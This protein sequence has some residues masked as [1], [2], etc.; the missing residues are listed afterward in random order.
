MRPED[1]EP[2]MTPFRCDALSVRMDPLIS[3]KG[4]LA[5]LD[6]TLGSALGAKLTLKSGCFTRLPTDSN[7]TAEIAETLGPELDR[8][9]CGVVVPAKFGEPSTGLEHMVR[10]SSNRIVALQPELP[11][12]A[13]ALLSAS[14]VELQFFGSP[15]R[16][17]QANRLA[18]WIPRMPTE[19]SSRGEMRKK[20]DA[21]RML[22]ANECVIGASIVPGSIQDDV[23]LL[24]DCGIDYIHLM[25]DAQYAFTASEGNR[26]LGNPDIM[27][28]QALAVIQDA[29]SSTKLLLSANA[30][31]AEQLYAFIDQGAFA[32]SIDA[33]V[34]C[35]IPPA[36]AP[37]T[38]RYASV[39]SYR[40]KSATTNQWIA[41]SINKMFEELDDLLAY[42]TAR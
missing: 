28:H 22:T 1:C 21:I 20:I 24:L 42:T 9:G 38:D 39:L 8:T 26:R 15:F 7:P 41:E 32:V 19:I 2:T 14:A 13:N 37:S 6:R 17:L 18:R 36:P 34:A 16:S 12:D 33:Y 25:A 4:S 35:R 3:T 40:T 29:N 5:T 30:T 31:T 23:R 10:R 27:L 11:I